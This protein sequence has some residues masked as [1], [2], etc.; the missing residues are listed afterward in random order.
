MT[1]L[2]IW[3]FAGE[4]RFR[5]ILPSYLLGASGAIFMYDITRYS[6]FKNFN[7]WYEVFLEGSKRNEAEIPLLIV[8]SKLD[9]EY[10]RAV[11]LEDAMQLTDSINHACDY[12]ECSA[13]TG[14][15]VDL[16]FRK[17]TRT[18]DNMNKDF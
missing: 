14:E 13:K 6:S 12:L 11:S 2:Q 10:K 18:M 15:N 3:D 1:T 17:I 5:F 4:S 16:I 7:S 8:G 9:L